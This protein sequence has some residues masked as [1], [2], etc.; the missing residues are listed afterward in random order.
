MPRTPAKKQTVT[1]SEDHEKDKYTFFWTTG[2]VNGWASQWYPSFFIVD[3]EIEEGKGK[4]HITFPTA[5]HW[6]MLQ[7]ALLFS[8]VNIARKIIDLASAG[9]VSKSDLK[10]I[11]SFGRKVLN[12]SED[13][14]K[15]NR[16]RIVLEGTLHKFRQ[17]ED[18]RNKLLGTGDTEIVEA[19][20][21]DRIWGIGYGEKNALAMKNKWGL[22]LLG[23]ALIEA[24][25]ILR[26]EVA[27]RDP[28][29]D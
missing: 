20:P 5:E 9:N 8:D 29:D 16:S 2:H 21:M 26:E 23:K 14:W 18:L 7:K 27:P 17:N 11:K 19:S 22:N 6:M 25:T 4:E 13:V 3:V 10:E 15:K 24:R 28:K 1:A 12:F